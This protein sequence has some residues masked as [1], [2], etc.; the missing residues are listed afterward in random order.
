[1]QT[2]KEKFSH[3]FTECFDYS[4]G[5]GW[6]PL[7]LAFCSLIKH[8]EETLQNSV[9]YALK[10]N[11]MPFWVERLPI[12]QESLKTFPVNIVQVKEK[13]G[14]LRIHHKGGPNELHQYARA[15]ELASCYICED[16]GK[17]A[18]GQT[19]GWIRTLCGSC[20]DVHVEKYRAKGYTKNS[21]PKFIRIEE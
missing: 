14:T 5:R 11:P 8:V 20:Y 2:A 12:V 18:E 15:L 13:F 9:S 16:C 21:I 1:M 10:D 19:D 17:R 3:Y 6:E 7:L 4:I